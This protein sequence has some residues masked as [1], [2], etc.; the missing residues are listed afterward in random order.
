MAKELEQLKHKAWPLRI[1]AWMNERFPPIAYVILIISYFSSNQFLAELVTWPGH[2]MTYHFGSL[3]GG[4]IVFCLFFHLRIFDEHKD[5]EEDCRHYPERVLQSG[6]I[7]LKDLKILGF[8]AIALELALGALIGLPALVAIA[9][10]IIYSL[11]MLKEFFIGGWLKKHFLVYAI[12]HMMIMP[13]FALVVY[14]ITS[15]HHFWEAPAVFWL[16]AFVGF[17]VTLNWEVSRKIRAP[18]DEIEGVDSYTQVFGTK[19]AAWM[20]IVIRIIDT[21][22]VMAVGWI[23]DFDWWFYVALVLLFVLCLWGFIDYL[24]N[25]NSKTAKRMETYAGLYII[26]F[27]LILAIQL[28]VRYGIHFKAAL[29]VDWS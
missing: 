3:L 23:Y 2:T 21:A 12:S 28:G 10:T 18:E 17:F 1:L 5:Y 29:G 8:I 19:G 24:R 14:S 11:L 25:T 7:N 20:V 22:M 6:V 27:D 13:L 9:V 16:Y 15:G 4:V 26:A